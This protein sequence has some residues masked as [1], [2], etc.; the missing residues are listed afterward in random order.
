MGQGLPRRSRGRNAPAIETALKQGGNR[1]A[2]VVRLPGLNHLLQP[3][4]T[5]LPAE[6]AQIE[7]TMAPAAL[8]AITTWIRERTGLAK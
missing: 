7:E 1:D 4:T 6:Y 3:A 8:D 5:G 2:T